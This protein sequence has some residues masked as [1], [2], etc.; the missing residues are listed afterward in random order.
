VEVKI[1]EEIIEPGAEGVIS[2]WLFKTGESVTQGDV[3]A[4]VMN[5]KAATQ[6]EAPASGRLTILVAS[7]VAIRCG[8]VIARID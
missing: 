2:V 5:A 4:E 6:L 7:E 1:P 8:D 3:L